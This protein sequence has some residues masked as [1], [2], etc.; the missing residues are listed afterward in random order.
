MT[1]QQV[2]LQLARGNPGKTMEGDFL[3]LSIHDHRVA[4]GE[5][6][7]DLYDLSLENFRALMR[8][9]MA[10]AATGDQKGK[11]KCD[12]DAFKF[13]IHDRLGILLSLMNCKFTLRSWKWAIFL[14]LGI[15]HF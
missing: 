10:A 1:I 4:L 11:R 2:N 8:M 6:V 9:A 15:G 12:Q 14:F 13:E 5:H 3:S 7:F